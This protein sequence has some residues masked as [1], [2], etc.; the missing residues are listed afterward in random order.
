MNL[1]SSLTFKMSCRYAENEHPSALYAET[2]AELADLEA[3]WGLKGISMAPIQERKGAETIGVKYNKV[4]KNSPIKSFVFGYMSR[5]RNGMPPDK[6]LYDDTFTVEFYPK[7]V[8]E[9]WKYLLDVVFVRYIAATQPYF[10]RL[11]D[12]D[13]HANDVA[14]FDEASGESALNPAYIDWRQ[15]VYRVWP[16]NFW[17]RELC[18]RSFGLSPEDVVRRLSGV[19]SSCRVLCDGVLVICSYEKLSSEEVLVLNQ[20]ILPLLA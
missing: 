10:G 20:K 19:V 17:D 8:Q 12:T 3:P 7:K 2:Y 4:G 15:G 13:I 18:R 11:Y 9:D 5:Q 16:A 14:P 6:A 1:P